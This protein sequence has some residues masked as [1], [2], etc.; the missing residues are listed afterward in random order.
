MVIDVIKGDEFEWATR[1]NLV[2]AAS[3]M[4]GKVCNDEHCQEGNREVER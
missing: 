3:V 1:R 4:D 2:E